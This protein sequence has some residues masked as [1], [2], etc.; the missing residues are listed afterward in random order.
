MRLAPNTPTPH[1]TTPH[2]R[3][4][5]FSP[6]YHTCQ[7]DRW[8]QRGLHIPHVTSEAMLV[9]VW[10]VQRSSGPTGVLSTFHVSQGFLHFMRDLPPICQRLWK[11]TLIPK[12]IQGCLHETAARERALVT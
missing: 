4:R 6:P 12:V 5:R 9:G 10:K 2:D 7:V 3:F 11:S 8:P 1:H